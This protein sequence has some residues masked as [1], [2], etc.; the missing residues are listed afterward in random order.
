M[1]QR[2]KRGDVFRGRVHQMGMW[3]IAHVECEEGEG[4]IL[5]IEDTRGED[6]PLALLHRYNLCSYF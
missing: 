5:V 3:C 4:N 1:K 2:Q 6:S